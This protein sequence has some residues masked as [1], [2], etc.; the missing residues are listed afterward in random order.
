MKQFNIFRELILTILL[1]CCNAVWAYD[2]E[3]DGFYYNITS[4][5]D[6]TVEVRHGDNKYFGDI[7]I[8]STITYKS[9]TFTVTSIGSSAFAYC[10]GLTSIIIP[11]SVTSIGG[12]AFSG[13]SSLTSIIIPDSV[14]IIGDGAFSGCSGLTS[15]VIPNS[16]TNIENYAFYNC[17]GL[18]S[19]EI[20][21]GV[22]SIGREAFAF[23]YALEAVYIND[24]EAWCKVDYYDRTDSNPLYYA[25][26]LYLNGELL[27]ELIIPDSL[28]A[29]KGHAFINC[30]NLTKVVIP[31]SVTSI[32]KWAFDGC[33]GL[34]EII[35]PNS[36]TS[37]GEYA[38][39]A[40]DNLKT[41]INLSRLTFESKSQDF[42]FVAYYANKVV[43]APNGSI[44]GDYVF[45]MID[46]V[47]TLVAYLGNDDELVLPDNY[48]AEK[49][50]IG[51]YAFSNYS[52][53]TSVAIPNSVTI[54]GD[55]AF[56]KC[57]G[58]TSI[59]IPNSVTSI[60]REAFRGCTGL[61]SIEIPNS[62]TSIGHDAFYACV[63]LT[64][65][66][67]P[68][69]VTY[70][71]DKAFSYCL[72][73]TSVVIPNLVKEIKYN[74][75]DSCYGLS[76]VTIGKCVAKIEHNA[77]KSCGALESIYLMA[78]APP[79][80]SS[81]SFTNA[82]YID[83]VLYVPTGC[84]EAY[85]NADVWNEFWEIKEFDTTGISDVKTENK[86]E[87]TIYDINGRVV[88]NPANGIYIVD[89]KKVLLR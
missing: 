41:V 75:F 68:E 63:G 67:I 58:L 40:C 28:T 80:V 3:V 71:G 50:V 85:Q 47:N 1:T 36:I 5:S 53:L 31:N 48:N 65:I 19:V 84:L 57:S 54:I 18:T 24:L 89:G 69:S 56:Y 70:I 87:T 74:L 38:F 52:N 79:T 62:V 15:I 76:S 25:E 13:C 81:S 20:G 78:E 55:C 10:T 82:H 86:K 2:I 51:N 35:I 12:S 34:T 61:T 37:I 72:S 16:V 17:K 11:N 27:T 14:T 64:S 88:E 21:T 6:L 26:K 77:F 66:I 73:L 44:I 9:R 45:G 60:G 4:A 46:K 43:N 83:A 42:G 49:Y 23:C 7:V 39:A 33:K 59:E 30:S 22:T 29:I 8:P 32:G